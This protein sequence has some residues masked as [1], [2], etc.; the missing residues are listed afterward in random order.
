MMCRSGTGC[1]A[2]SQACP[3][4]LP[5]CCLQFMKRSEV[6]PVEASNEELRSHMHRLEERRSS[7]EEARIQLGDRLNWL[8]QHVL[9][10]QVSG[11][12][13]TPSRSAWCKSL[14]SL[15]AGAVRPCTC[16]PFQNAPLKPWLEC[17]VCHSPALW[18]AATCLVR[19]W[20][21]GREGR[22]EGG[23]QQNWCFCAT[24]VAL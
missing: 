15:D 12:A 13:L 4:L 16:Y 21:A 18:P 17:L 10:P 19:G 11:G 6:G 9:P 8:A 23:K 22:R 3:H 14:H 1:M 7:L 24:E 2:G 20:D 5:P